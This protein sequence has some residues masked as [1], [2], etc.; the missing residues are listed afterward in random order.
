MFGFV[1]VSRMIWISGILD[2]GYFLRME[3]HGLCG[4]GSANG[5]NNGG[6]VNWK[7]H[8]ALETTRQFGGFHRHFGI[9]GKRV[10][11]NI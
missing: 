10:P 11:G 5:G 2:F 8:H 7:I 1:S 6:T 4:N 9:N 3:N